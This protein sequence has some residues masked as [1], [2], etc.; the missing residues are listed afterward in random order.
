M[1]DQARATAVLALLI[2]RLEKDHYDDAG[3]CPGCGLTSDGEGKEHVRCPVRTAVTLARVE[4]SA[5]GAPSPEATRAALKSL[6]DGAI[7]VAPSPGP[8]PPYVGLGVHYVSHGSPRRDDGSQDYPSVCRAATV[9]V[10]RDTEVR[11]WAGS[12]PQEL[13]AC[14]VG[15]AVLSE[16]GLLFADAQQDE[17]TFAGGTWHFMGNGPRCPL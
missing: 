7:P 10:L 9:T 12:E 14:T 17:D 13:G 8:F 4:L 5:S 16:G 11:R 15:L 2:A 3:R 1:I 6:Q